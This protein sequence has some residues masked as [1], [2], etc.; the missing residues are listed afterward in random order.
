MTKFI[1]LLQLFILSAFLLATSCKTKDITPNGNTTSNTEGV[2]EAKVDGVLVTTLAMTGSANLVESVGTLTIQGNTGGT[3]S[4]SFSL[5]INGF[6]NEGVY[7]IGGNNNVGVSASYTETTVNIS[8]PGDVKTNTWQ[9]PYTGGAEVGTITITELST[10]NIK[11]TFS[12]NAKH[13]EDQS[14]K[15]ITEGTFN[16]KLK[17]S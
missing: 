6:E 16:M 12:F 14:L 9:A 15:E 5:I 2:I 1:Q 11:G 17:R 10:D 8:S 4:K 7:T 3:N 13:N